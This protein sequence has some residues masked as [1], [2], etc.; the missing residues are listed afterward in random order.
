MKDY[1]LAGN[2]EQFELQGKHTCFPVDHPSKNMRINL[3]RSRER[4]VA[5]GNACP[6]KGA[7]LHKGIIKDIEDLE[8]A[9]VSCVLHGWTFS[10]VDGKSR[11]NNFVIDVYDV[12]LDGNQIWISMEATNQGITGERRN[13]TE[14]VY[15][16]ALGWI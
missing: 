13:L 11:A 8:R 9:S 4:L 16:P 3:I 12:K 2:T 6:H 5:I 10:L 7:P 14:L 15:N 1:F